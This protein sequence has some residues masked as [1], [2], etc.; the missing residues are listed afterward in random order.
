MDL[1][2]NLLESFPAQ[3]ADGANYKVKAY[4]RQ[5]ADPNLNDGQQHWQSTGVAE[6]RLDDGT[7]VDVRADG[8]MRIAGSDRELTRA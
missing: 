7:L 6:Y 4:E 3:G 1:R 5:V 8:S 2:L